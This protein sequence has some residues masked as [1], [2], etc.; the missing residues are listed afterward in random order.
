MTVSEWLDQTLRDAAAR[1]LG[2]LRPM[3]EALARASTTLRQAPW[4]PDPRDMRPPT[5]R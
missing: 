2:E 4:N 1:G 5:A 3:L